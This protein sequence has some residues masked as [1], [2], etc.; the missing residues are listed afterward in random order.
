ML[1]HIN[2][3]TPQELDKE[4]REFFVNKLNS[5][6]FTPNP[7]KTDRSFFDRVKEM[8]RQLTF[9]SVQVTCNA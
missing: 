4:E 9:Y 5:D 8:F 3:W 2:I 7:E 6:N 1:V